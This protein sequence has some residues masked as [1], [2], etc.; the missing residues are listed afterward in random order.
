MKNRQTLPGNVAFET[1]STHAGAYTERAGAEGEAIFPTS[2]LHFASAA[3]AAESCSGCKGSAVF[4]DS[5]NATVSLF[6]QRMMALEGAEAA[7]ATS[8][9]TAAIFALCMA[10][11][12]PGDHIL[13]ARQMSGSTIDLIS[14][15]LVNFGITSSFVDVSDQN[16]W[17]DSVHDETKM[18]FVESPSYPLGDIADFEVLKEVAEFSNAL[19]VVD[20]ALCTPALQQPL[21][22]GADLVVYS[23]ANYLDGQGLCRGGLVLGSEA[24]MAPVR[25]WRQLA[26]SHL[27][28]NDAW[29]LLKGLETLKLRMDSH[30]RNTQQLAWFLAEHES[31]IDVH[32]SGLP[33]HAGAAL[34]RKQQQGYGALVAFEVAGGRQAAWQ[35][36]DGVQLMMRT[37]ELGDTRTTITHP[38]ST[39]HSALTDQ[40][41]REAGITEGLVCIAV[42][43]E[44]IEDLKADLDQA[45]ARLGSLS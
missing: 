44:N 28:P 12:Q 13:C 2:R 32:Y 30:C 38:A 23:M 31:V 20:N 24:L 45:L 15:T 22:W 34:A 43:L 25:R 9:G 3:E 7:C 27:N 4:G 6:E 1:L 18:I 16:A 10:H 17:L 5:G 14:N 36:I 35:V 29:S 21:A 40:E 8:S 26:G 39:T 11:L 42:G 37:A 19:L 41:K 33:F